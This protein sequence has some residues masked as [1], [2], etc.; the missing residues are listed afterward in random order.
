MKEGMRVAQQAAVD[1]M[2]VGS[3]LLAQLQM[4]Q[5]RA[6]WNILEVSKKVCVLHHYMKK[7]QIKSFLI[8]ICQILGDL[9]ASEIYRMIKFQLYA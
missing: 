4:Q 3:A 6:C 1:D 5:D 9:V 7:T 8:S 2:V